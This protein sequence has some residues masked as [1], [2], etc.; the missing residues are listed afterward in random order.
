MDWSNSLEIYRQGISGN[1]STLCDDPRFLNCRLYM[2]NV[3]GY[4]KYGRWICQTSSWFNTSIKECPVRNWFIIRS[5]D[6]YFQIGS[7]WF[8][9]ELSGHYCPVRTA[10]IEKNS[11]WWTIKKWLEYSQFILFLFFVEIFMA[12]R[13]EQLLKIANN[14]K[15]RAIIIGQETIGI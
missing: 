1:L 15:F 8:Y 4:I 5:T 3:S 12:L 11:P 13:Q 2:N 10:L 9:S 14:T 7:N 6:L